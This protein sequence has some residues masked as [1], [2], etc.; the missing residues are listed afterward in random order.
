LKKAI[1]ENHKAYL[2][3]KSLYKSFGYNVDKERNFIIKQAGSLCGKILEAG[4][5]KGHFALALAKKG[6]KFTTFDI[7]KAEQAFAKLNLKYF[8]LDKQVKLRIENGENLNFKDKSFDVIFSVNTLHHLADP[9]NVID[10]FTRILSP[11]GKIVLSDFTK[12]GLKIIDKIHKLEG[13]VHEVSRVR[14]SD[15]SRYLRNKGF[16]VQ[17]SKSKYQQILIAYHIFNLAK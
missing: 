2:Q 5:G 6:Y 1:I 9:Y 11:R 7:S 13:K 8:G 14:L 15:V 17:K 3:R 12:D 4:T 16:R 10:E